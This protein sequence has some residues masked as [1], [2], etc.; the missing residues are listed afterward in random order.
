MLRG[1]VLLATVMGCLGAQHLQ[2]PIVRDEAL[3]SEPRPGAAPSTSFVSL[4]Q[5]ELE[6]DHDW[7][8]FKGL[9]LVTTVRNQHAPHYCGA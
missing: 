3:W 2:V 4:G 8:N 7:R 9:N 6:T 1:V 5:D